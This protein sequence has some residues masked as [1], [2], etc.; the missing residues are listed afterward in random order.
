VRFRLVPV[1]YGIEIVGA[2]VGVAVLDG[3]AQRLGERDRRIEMK[4]IERPAAADA[5]G[6]DHGRA[7]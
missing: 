3:G 5:F 4:A 6:S 7:E 2:V 1:G